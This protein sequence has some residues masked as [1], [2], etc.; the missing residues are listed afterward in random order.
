MKSCIFWLRRSNEASSLHTSG[1]SGIVSERTEA[2]DFYKTR[3][4]HS[5]CHSRCS[6]W[7]SDTLEQVLRIAA[8]HINELHTPVTLGTALKQ[9]FAKHSPHS[10]HRCAY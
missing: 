3:L 2:V 4:R 6:H 1:P 10:S 5:T 7:N 9:V 8:A